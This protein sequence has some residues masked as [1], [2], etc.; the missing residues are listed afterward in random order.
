MSAAPSAP[1]PDVSFLC[2]WSGGKDSCL[3][4]YRAAQAGAS[5]RFL[6]T[7]LEED[8]ERSRSH[9]LRR[10]V[11]QAQAAA[12]GIPLVT[13]ATSWDEYES[14]FVAALRD[15]K[16]AGVEAG[17]FGDIDLE[18][19]LAWERKVCQMGG[20]EP[21][22][23]LWKTPRLA[24]LDEFLACGFEATIVVVRQDKLDRAYLGQT[25]DAE[26]VRQFA[27]LGVDPAGE[28]GEYHTVV[29]DGPIFSERLVL[30]S[31]DAVFHSGC[32]LLDLRVHR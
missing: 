17:V 29:T 30:E 22:L 26:L 27:K 1:G 24:L 13:R 20:I 5:P 6:L 25:L 19:H 21:H 12:L 7:M 32:W 18:E 15:L 11:L 16:A 9:G 10:E 3:A 8:G 31:G 28:E 2:S 23:P 4:L 14:V